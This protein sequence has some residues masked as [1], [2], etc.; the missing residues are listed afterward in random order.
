[1]AC[2]DINGGRLKDSW[3][4]TKECRIVSCNC[5][6]YVDDDD[7]SLLEFPVNSLRSPFKALSRELSR[8]K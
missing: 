7:V 2:H 1:M 3:R 4:N 8:E 5:W 6:D